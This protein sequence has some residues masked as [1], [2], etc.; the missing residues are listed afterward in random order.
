MN[1]KLILLV[2]TVV[3]LLLVAGSAMAE[4]R[5]C[6]QCNADVTVQYHDNGDGA[7]HKVTYT[8]THTNPSDESHS[9]SDPTCTSAARCVCG[10]TSG[11]ALDRKSVV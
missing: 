11:S 5:F 10:A 4:T 7:T 8:C 9:Y 3:A 6:P 1:K 2:L